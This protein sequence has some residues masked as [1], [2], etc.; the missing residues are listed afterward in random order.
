MPFDLPHLVDPEA[1]R[2]V[3]YFPGSTIGNFTVREALQFLRNARAL[4][5]A[6]GAMLVGVDL[7]KDRAVLHAAYNDA[8]GVTAA[9]NLNLLARLNREL[10]ADF[11]LSALVTARSTMKALDALK[12]IS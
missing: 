2:R 10:G 4:A 8:Q 1:A 6:G 3:V 9:F 5:G 7:K 11:D 12:C